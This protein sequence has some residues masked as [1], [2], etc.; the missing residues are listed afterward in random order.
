MNQNEE[1]IQSEQYKKVGESRKF[2]KVY[3]VSFLVVVSTLI[4]LSYFSQEK[5]NEQIEQL[6]LQVDDKQ[7]EVINHMNSAEELQNFLEIQEELMKKRENMIEQYEQQIENFELQIDESQSKVKFLEDYIV[8]NS[9]FIGGYYTECLDFAY[10]IASSE[11]YQGIKEQNL[12]Q[13]EFLNSEVIIKNEI[14]K[15]INYILENDEIMQMFTANDIK[16]LEDIQN[17]R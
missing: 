11:T 17:M 15:S 4:T 12:S 5:L 7:N 9:L 3:M 2:L 14:D 13:E 10:E 6:A 16:K 8:F 1:D